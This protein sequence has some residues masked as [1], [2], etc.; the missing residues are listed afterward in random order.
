MR[1]YGDF[2]ALHYMWRKQILQTGLLLPDHPYNECPIEMTAEEHAT[3]LR[4]LMLLEKHPL[5]N[6]RVRTLLGHPIIV[7]HFPRQRIAL[8]RV[9]IDA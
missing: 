1:K 9:L 2:I 4:D 6:D 3:L 8:P 5:E 7:N